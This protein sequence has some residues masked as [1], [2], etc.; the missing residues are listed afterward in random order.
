MSSTRKLFP[1]EKDQLKLVFSDTETFT[2]LCN[3]LEKHPIIGKVVEL[4]ENEDV[5]KLGAEMEVLTPTDIIEETMDFYPGI[6]AMK[7]GYIPIARCLLGSG[8]SYFVNMREN[9]LA[10]FRIPHD[11]ITENDLLDDN[12]IEYVGEIDIL[13]R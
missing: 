12:Q 7:K 8:D 3:I 2:I 6:V 11:S 10:V 9:K 4:S 13:I 1:K 5:S